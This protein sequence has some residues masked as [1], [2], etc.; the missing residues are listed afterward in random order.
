MLLKSTLFGVLLSASI[1]ASALPWCKPFQND[2]EY[3][4]LLEDAGTSPAG[5]WT[6][7]ECVHKPTARFQV[8][9]TLTRADYA[10][11]VSIGGKLD[12]ANKSLSSFLA[13]WQRNVTL[14]YSDPSLDAVRAHFLSVHPEYA[15]V[16]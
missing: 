8:N 12:T 10:T 7:Y 16:R 3:A 5:H 13:S 15:Y 1:S 11:F 14:P 4:S 2:A 6:V 9:I